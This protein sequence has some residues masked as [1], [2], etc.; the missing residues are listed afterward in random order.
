MKSY[1]MAMPEIKD[2]MLEPKAQDK[3]KKSK[4]FSSETDLGISNSTGNSE[5]KTL[6][7]KTR[8]LYRFD[9]QALVVGG[10]YT[11][12]EANSLL[13]S[14]NWNFNVA[15]YKRI[16]P[17]FSLIIGD[18]IEGN[19]FQQLRQRDNIDLGGKYYFIKKSQNQFNLQLGY[20]YTT[21]KY[22]ESEYASMTLHK[23]RILAEWKRKVG[24]DSKAFLIGDYIPNFSVKKDWLAGFEFG[25]SNKI[26]DLFALKVSYK[27]FYDN[28]PAS[29]ELK[30]QDGL[31]LTSFTISFD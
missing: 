26:N 2:D 29:P 3:I 31:F 11:Y 13:N 25:L 27:Y 30:K 15:Y 18:T 7:F 24:K 1:A 20:R 14:Q 22:Y 4:Y 17:N 21:E 8:N 23:G 12:G 6:S 9:K 16:N 5:Y 19:K 10:H 28:L